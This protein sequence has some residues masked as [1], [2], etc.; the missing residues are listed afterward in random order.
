V[1]SSVVVPEQQYSCT[2]CDSRIDLGALGSPCCASS[3]KLFVLMS[4]RVCVAR[5]KQ[6]NAEAGSWKVVRHLDS[7]LLC[8]C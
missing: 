1:L 6:V 2:L 4:S 7:D 5:I 3:K 8:M